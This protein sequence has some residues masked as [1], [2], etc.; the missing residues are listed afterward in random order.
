MATLNS[1]C[2]VPVI[3]KVGDTI[4]E[5]KGSLCAVGHFYSKSFMI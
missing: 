4:S 3:Y 1:L 2:L 5:K